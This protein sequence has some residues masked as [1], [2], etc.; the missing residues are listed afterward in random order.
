MAELSDTTTS[1]S[2]DRSERPG[3]VGLLLALAGVLVLAFAGL[4]LVSNE[5]AQPIIL[6]L[7]A[8]LAMA[9]VFFVFAVAVGAVRFRGGGG[10]Y[11]LGK[12]IA[13]GAPEGLVVVEESG[14]VVY[15]NERY[16]RLS[17]TK[18][19]ADLRSVERLFT[20]GPEVS[21]AVY[22]L[23]QA[24][25]E[26]RPA[27]EEVRLSPALE[28]GQEFGWYRLRVRS[29]ARPGGRMATL[30]SVSDVTRDRERQENVF[31]ELQ[32]AIDY[33]DHAPAG[34]FSIGAEGAIVY[35]NATLAAWLD[36]DLAKVGSGGLKLA[37]IM[38]DPVVAMLTS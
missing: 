8:L 5:Q 22:R 37:D 17:G 11:D 12:A 28:G 32:H 21:E 31:Q 23:A 14:R 18:K 26:H 20:G 38:P 9:G 1:M 24:A 25:R 10:R 16:L 34:F 27:V 36:Y 13:D 33:L 7:L 2:I 19:A 35:M 30:W 29:I 6:A 15:A 4:T 3:H